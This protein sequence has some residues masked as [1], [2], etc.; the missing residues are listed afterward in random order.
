MWLENDTI[1][2]N[3]LLDMGCQSY[4]DSSLLGFRV[5]RR[6]AIAGGKWSMIGVSTIPDVHCMEHSGV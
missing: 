5:I 4:I 6:P 2:N 3:D 1:E